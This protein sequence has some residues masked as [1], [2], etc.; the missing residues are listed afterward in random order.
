[1]VNLMF[2]LPTGPGILDFDNPEWS[3]QFLL[4]L[5]M[6]IPD[7][8]HGHLAEVARAF[9]NQHLDQP[10][11]P[12]GPAATSALASLRSDGFCSLGQLL[13]AAQLAD[14]H[15]YLEPNALVDSWNSDGP[16]FPRDQVPPSVNVAEYDAETVVRA[17]HLHDAVVGQ[18]VFPVVSNYLG[19]PP[20]V[21]YLLSWWSLHDRDQARDAQFFHVDAHDFKWVK[22]FV[23]LTDVDANAGPHVMVRGSH[24]RAARNERLAMLSKTDPEAAR[25]IQ[26]ALRRGERFDDDHVAA[27]FGA[28]NFMSL[29]G[30]AGEAFLVDT[31]AI[32][33]GLLPISRDRL[34]F[35]ALYT[36]LPTIKNPVT[37]VA[38]PG[39]YRKYAASAAPAA[40][41]SVLWKYCN[42]LISRDP[43]IES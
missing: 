25:A 21:P 4:Q 20:T 26:D 3:R 32:H 41:P 35:Q 17:P 6:N 24:D 13:S 42:R 30:R 5:R 29:E 43:E 19:V 11:P 15:A 34:V 28:E 16:R 38:L 14:I 8:A 27:M 2:V 37:P 31:A 36:L 7:A 18:K 22:L 9:I 33:K 23:Y 12:C 10:I 1:L 39:A 40:M